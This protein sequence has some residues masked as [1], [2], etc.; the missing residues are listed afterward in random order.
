MSDDAL[1]IFDRNNAPIG[2][3]RARMAIAWYYN[4]PMSTTLV[5]GAGHEG[6]QSGLM[7]AGNRVLVISDD[8]P[9]WAGVILPPE[10]WQGGQNSFTVH[11]SEKILEGRWCDP[12]NTFTGTGGDVFEQLLNQ[13]NL[14]STGISAGEIDRAGGVITREYHRDKIA[15]AMNKL[16]SDLSSTWWVSGALNGNSLALTARWARERGRVFETPLVEAESGNLA[17]INYSREGFFANRIQAIGQTND[18][19]NPLVS[20]IHE[21]AVSQGKHGVWEYPIMAVSAADKATLDA[22]A[23]SALSR[24]RRPRHAMT[25]RITRAPYP[26]PGDQVTVELS[27]LG[28]NDDGSTGARFTGRVR[29]LA[30]DVNRDVTIL[31]KED[32]YDESVS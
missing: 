5:L 30:R 14:L 32:L 16:A 13:A 10:N 6:L 9:A 3:I 17:D 19:N 20:D 23:A 25:A 18:W 12:F 27:T 31:V 26:A 15:E 24:F 2:Q 29:E 22:L 8:L 1:L 7:M 4:R 21:D 11:S 28:F